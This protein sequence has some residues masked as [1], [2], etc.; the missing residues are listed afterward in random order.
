MGN[1]KI[2]TI[3]YFFKILAPNNINGINI[4]T[5]VESPQSQKNG[6]AVKTRPLLLQRKLT[7]VLRIHISSLK[8][9]VSLLPPGHLTP[10]YRF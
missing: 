10:L 9:L 3:N 2:Y 6:S 4:L 7:L 5:K 1:Y 8:L